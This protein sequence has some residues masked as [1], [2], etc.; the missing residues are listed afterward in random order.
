MNIE[1]LRT[2]LILANTRNY[3]RT[4]GQL[5]IAQSTVTNRINELEKELQVSLLTRT[6]RS[7]ELTPEGIKF[8]EYASKVI[9]L[10]NSSLAELTSFQKYEEHLRIGASDSIYEGHLAPIILKHQ[11]N[12][13]HH[14]LKITIG[15]SSH[16]LELLQNDILDVVF[17]YLPLNQSNFH[18]EIFKQDSMVLVTDQCN[19]KFKDGITKEALLHEN[20]LM[21]NFALQDVGQFIRG[22]FP[23]YHQFSLEIDDCSKI[24]PFLL[25]QNNYTFLP[26]DMAEPFLQDEKLHIIPLLDFQTP[27]INSYIIGKKSKQ[28]SWSS[29]FFS[30]H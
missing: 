25:G 7:V 17:T 9:D 11:R 24:I 26:Q 14:S 8:Q 10:T 4:A 18:C 12:H 5:F 1:S 27:V 21:C 13:P 19:R 15:L 29:I 2:F 6:N 22:L 16:L 23:K 30:E 3:T 28:K 20:Y